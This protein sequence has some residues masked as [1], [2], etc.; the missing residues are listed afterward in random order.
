VRM[1]SRKPCVLA[2]LRLFGWKVRLLT[3][4][5]SSHR[6]AGGR[7]VSCEPAWSRQ[8]CYASGRPLRVVAVRRVRAT[9]GLGRLEQQHTGPA[10]TNR[11]FAPGR[12]ALS[13]AG[14]GHVH[15]RETACSSPA[16]AGMFPAY[17]LLDASANLRL[18]GGAAVP[19]HNARPSAGRNRDTPM[20]GPC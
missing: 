15:T 1:R 19:L 10:E 14:T 3:V 8:V 2:R 18:A 20:S 6:P 13:M 11:V 16:C 17:G 9:R 12:T 4:S 5:V 7:R